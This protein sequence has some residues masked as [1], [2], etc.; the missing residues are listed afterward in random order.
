VLGGDGEVAPT[1]SIND[2]P[3]L[4]SPFLT[5]IERFGCPI[6]IA[7]PE[8]LAVAPTICCR[9]GRA[10]PSRRERNP[11]G[12]LFCVSGHVNNPCWI[13]EGSRSRS[14]MSCRSTAGVIEED[15]MT[16]W[17]SWLE[18]VVSRSSGRICEKVWL[19][20]FRRLFIRIPLRRPSSNRS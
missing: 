17:V 5:L 16:S 1:E 10:V 6:T 3:R 15:G 2:I 13:E 18:A 8:T 19:F 9:V 7:R 11:G 12:R 14:G 4:K 20:Y